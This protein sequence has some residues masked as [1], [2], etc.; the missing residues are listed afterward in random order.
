MEQQIEELDSQTNEPEVAENTEVG[1]PADAVEVEPIDEDIEEKETLKQ[2]NQELYEQ[3][4]KAKGFVRDRDG[5]WIKKEVLQPIKEN[6]ISEDITRTELY[7][8]MKANVPDEDTQEVIVY[9]KSHGLS[10]TEALKTPEVK[11]LLSV[12]K[13]YRNTAEATNISGSR[14]GS[15]KI[16]DET[17]LANASKGIMPSTDEDL[18]RL[19]KAKKGIKD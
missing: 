1:L 19:I 3:L 8:M 4:K 17:L 2:R 5:K 18:I 9:A 10:V 11:A 14:R 16:S 12:R 15:T 13:E 7:S 6:K